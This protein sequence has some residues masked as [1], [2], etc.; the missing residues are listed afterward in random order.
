MDPESTL[1][2]PIDVGDRTLAMAQHVVHQV[3][4]V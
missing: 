2:L 3:I 4:Q 1:L